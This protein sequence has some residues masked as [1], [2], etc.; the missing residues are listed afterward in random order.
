M[1]NYYPNSICFSPEHYESKQ[2]PIDDMY[3]DINTFVKI[4]LTTENI[5]TF[6]NTS[7]LLDS[8]NI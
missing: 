1:N 5:N 3:Y 4:L 6:L 7:K 8:K 2:L